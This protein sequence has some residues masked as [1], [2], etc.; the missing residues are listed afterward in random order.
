VVED[1]LNGLLVPSGD[2][3]ALAAAV[4][5]FLED[6]ALVERLRANA[7]PSIERYSRER[8]YGRLLEIL[9]GAAR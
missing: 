8:V 4:R 3:A 1:G 6:P 7:A 5:R 2:G 9:S